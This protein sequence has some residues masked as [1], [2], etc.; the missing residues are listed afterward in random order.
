MI[1]KFFSS[2]FKA[3]DS[4]ILCWAKV[5]GIIVKLSMLM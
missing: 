5:L 3:S 1:Y 4:V 2:D